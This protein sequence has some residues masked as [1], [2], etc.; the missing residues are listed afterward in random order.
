MHDLQTETAYTVMH[1]GCRFAE[2]EYLRHKAEQRRRSLQCSGEGGE[3]G[4]S[5]DLRQLLGADSKA[6]C[7]EMVVRAGGICILYTCGTEVEHHLW[8]IVP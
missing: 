4:G 5:G 7:S 1:V 3:R 6:T 8:C 2:V